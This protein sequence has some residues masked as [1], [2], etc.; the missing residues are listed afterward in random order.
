[1]SKRK[2][3][4][5]GSN[6]YPRGIVYEDNSVMLNLSLGMEGMDSGKQKPNMKYR[7]RDNVFV[8]YYNKRNNI[9]LATVYMLF[10]EEIKQRYYEIE[11]HPP[12]TSP[13]IRVE[14]RM[15]ILSKVGGVLKE[16]GY[17][18]IE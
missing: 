1:M 4:I 15:R 3:V 17:E 11:F 13:I 7:G 2:K 12:I 6:L 14:S 5:L 9:L 8:E 18:I 16:N 10:D